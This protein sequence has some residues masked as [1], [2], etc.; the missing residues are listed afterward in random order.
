MKHTAEIVGRNALC[1]VCKLSGLLSAVIDGEP[2][3]Y[4]RFCLVDT[5]RDSR[6]RER[7]R[8]GE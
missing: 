5:Y 3:A 7:S 4:C 8:D 6:M 1:P 2:H